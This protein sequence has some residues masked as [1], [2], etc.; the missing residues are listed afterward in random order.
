M[1]GARR[2]GFELLQR[3]ACLL[4]LAPFAADPD[5]EFQR[6]RSLEGAT[7][8]EPTEHPLDQVQRRL[9]IAPIQGHAGPAERADRMRPREVLLRLLERP[10]RRRNSP[11]RSS[12]SRDQAAWRGARPGPA[13]AD[14][15]L[16]PSAP[17]R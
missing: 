12:A 15:P 8:S 11:S 6:G 14:P 7:A 5:Q 10:C 16:R 4:D 3:L 17:G 13:R 1:P 9:V 2:D